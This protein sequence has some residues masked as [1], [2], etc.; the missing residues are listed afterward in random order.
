[1]IGPLLNRPRLSPF[2]AN[3]AVEHMKE[4]SNVGVKSLM[5]N[6]YC[7]AVHQWLEGFR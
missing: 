5:T 7:L 2:V 4:R 1:M 6:C 3:K